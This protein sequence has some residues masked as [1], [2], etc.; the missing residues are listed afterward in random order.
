MIKRKKKE[1]RPEEKKKSTLKKNT[2]AKILRFV[3]WGMM[4]FLFVRGMVAIL[5]P[6]Q[7]EA[8]QTW[9]KELETNTQK[10][11]AQNT[12]IL[13]FT[14]D[15][16]QEWFTYTNEDEFKGRLA[17]YVVPAVMEQQNIHD[18]KST[19]KVTRTNAY[20]TE[21]YAAGHFDVYVSVTHTNTKLVTVEQETTGNVKKK[22]EVKESTA[23][24][25]A[26]TVESSEILKVPVQLTEDDRYIIEGIPLIVNDVE[27]LPGQYQK[28]D[29]SLE[30]IEDVSLYQETIT[31]YLRAYYSEAQSVTDYYLS[32]DAEKEKLFG[33]TEQGKVELLTVKEVKAYRKAAGEVLCLVTY[34]IRNN[35]SQ[36]ENLQQCNILLDDREM[37]RLYIKDMD[38]KL[39]N[40]RLEAKE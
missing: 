24:Q 27:Y 29:V 5:K 15:F 9:I 10:N 30:K 26:V 25:E 31:N 12:E 6:D 17:P 40:L 33:F 8:L 22:T 32:V 20:R 11:I 39:F 35:V 34:Q 3:L 37:G 14:E 36:A 13:S 21:Q 19:S 38:T 4:A 7:T 28:V 16:V 18:F 23:K 2:T 1:E